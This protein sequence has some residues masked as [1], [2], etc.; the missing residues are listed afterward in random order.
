VLNGTSFPS[1][2]GKNGERKT[3]KGCPAYRVMLLTIRHK[4]A[5]RQTAVLIQKQ[6]DDSQR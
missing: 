4:I 3:D 2:F 6:S 1:S 5:E